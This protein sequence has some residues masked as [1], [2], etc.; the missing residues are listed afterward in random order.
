MSPDSADVY[1]SDGMTEELITSLSGIRELT[2]IARTS[3]MKY[4]STQKGISEIARELNVGTLIEGSVRKAGNR[5]RI[6]VQLIDAA[7][8]GHIWARNYD[9]QL[10]DIFAIQSEIAEKVANE[11]SVK[12]VSSERARLE[13]RPTEDTEVYMLYLKG[14]HY[15]NERSDEGLLKA[16]SYFEKAVERDKDF[17]LGYSG[18]ADCYVVMGRNGPGPSA[19]S[20]EKARRP[21][22]RLWSWILASPKPTLP[23]AASSTTPTTTGGPQR[24]STRGRSSSNRTTRRHIS[25]THIYW[26]C[27]DGS[28]KPRPR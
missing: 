28:R 23:S 25:G 11:L 7:T 3:T 17:A 12:L 9:R 16:I 14:R 8:E 2:V 21:S 13:R 18:L 15:W 10:D 5:V 1:L 20:Y 26:S 4:R 27:G 24:Q 19:P 6:T 22:K